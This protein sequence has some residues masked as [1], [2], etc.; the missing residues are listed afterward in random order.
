MENIIIELTRYSIAIVDLVLDNEY[1]GILTIL[2]NKGRLLD[3][4]IADC[5]NLN[6]SII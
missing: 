5:G 2:D 6:Q 1:M 4:Q 3:I